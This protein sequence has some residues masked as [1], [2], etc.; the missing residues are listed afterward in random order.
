MKRS[1]FPLALLTGGAL[2]GCAWWSGVTPLPEG[3][4]R[5]QVEVANLPSAYRLQQQAPPCISEALDEAGVATDIVAVDRIASFTKPGLVRVD[6][7]AKKAGT[8][9]TPIKI[10][11]VLN[12]GDLDRPVDLRLTPDTTFDITWRAYH[13][14]DAR[15]GSPQVLVEAQYNG[16]GEASRTL[17]VATQPRGGTVTQN[18]TIYL[19]DRCY[20]GQFGSGTITVD[21]NAAASPTVEHL[22]YE[23]GPT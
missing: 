12:N 16:P 10:V 13:P 14:R 2:A 20:A 7:Y 1:L 23:P 3:G 15:A 6:F 9:E 5:L 22:P 21:T 18:V 4:V 8:A 19:A 11:S 17:Q